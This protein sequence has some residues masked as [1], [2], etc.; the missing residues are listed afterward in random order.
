MAAEGRK[1]LPKRDHGFPRMGHGYFIA[2]AIFARDE[3]PGVPFLN[4]ARSHSLA[5]EQIRA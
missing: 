4:P 1:E 3:V 2:L 5:P